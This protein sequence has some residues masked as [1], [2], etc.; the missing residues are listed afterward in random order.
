MSVE[1]R[2]ATSDTPLRVYS[3]CVRGKPTLSHFYPNNTSAR[4]QEDSQQHKVPP[5]PT[6]LIGGLRREVL[7]DGT[8]NNRFAYWSAG[9][10]L[11]TSFSC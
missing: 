2:L 3:S 5:N 10:D 9:E 4:Q 6:C 8:K 7:R 1:I 11:T